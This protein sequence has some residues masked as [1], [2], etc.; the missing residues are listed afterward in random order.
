MASKTLQSPKVAVP[1]SNQARGKQNYIGVQ[2]KPWGK[3]GARIRVPS[4]NSKQIW[5]GSYETDIDA[6]RAYNEAA[7][8]H[9]TKPT[10][11][12][13]PDGKKEEVEGDNGVIVK[14][15]E[16]EGDNKV[17]V[18]EEELEGDYKVIVKEEELEG[19]NEVIVKKEELEGDYKVIVKKEELEGDW[20]E[21]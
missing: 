5:L 9:H 6:A 14:K 12:V 7:L 19:D 4:Q 11:N 13:L 18:K 17:I 16:L 15:E 3:F 8:E 1:S 21:E 20:P 2:K 10:L